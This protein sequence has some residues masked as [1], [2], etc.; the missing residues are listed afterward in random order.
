[1]SSNL[2]LSANERIGRSATGQSSAPAHIGAYL[3]QADRMANLESSSSRREC[4]GAFDDVLNDAHTACHSPFSRYRD[5]FRAGRAGKALLKGQRL[6][7]SPAD[8]RH[9]IERRGEA[10]P[11]RKREHRASSV[12]VVE[13][14]DVTEEG[15]RL[16]FSFPTCFLQQHQRSSL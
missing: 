3:L 14:F 13:R 9:Q 10:K 7:A 1:V 11:T 4:L 12:L 16:G 6:L 15:A 8:I 5:H 2:T